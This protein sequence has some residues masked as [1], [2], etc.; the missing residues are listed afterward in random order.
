MLFSH[1]KSLPQ[2]S[3]VHIPAAAAVAH[4]DASAAHHALNAVFNIVVAPQ[5]NMLLMLLLKTLNP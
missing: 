4:G 1:L 5:V 3:S 2:A